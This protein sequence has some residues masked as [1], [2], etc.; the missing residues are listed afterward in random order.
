MLINKYKPKSSEEVYGQD[1]QLN[2]LKK[3]ILDKKPVLVYGSTGIGKT[4]SAYAL[5]Y[6][7]DYEILE[8]NASDL[9]NKEQIQTIV[10]NNLQQKSLFNKEKLVLID[11][12]DGINANDRGG[13]QE[14]LKLLH[15]KNFA[16]V[17]IANDPWNSKFKNLRKKCKL[18]EFKKI[19]NEII[20]N[21]INEINEK[22]KLNIPQDILKGISI[23][24]KGDLRSAILDLELAKISNK[25]ID[26][27]EKKENI[28]NVLK[29]LFKNKEFNANI[30]NNLDIDLDEI[31]LWLEENIPYE[32]SNGELEKAFNNLSKADIYRGRIKRWQY[33]RFLVY[34]NLLMAGIS[35]AKDKVNNKF[36]NYSRNSRILKIWIYNQKNVKKKEF[37]NNLAPNLHMSSKKLLHEMP[38]MKFL[39]Y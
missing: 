39:K 4:A 8:I 11:E 26:L 14:L 2:E 30:F 36:T 6:D 38:Y 19:D 35:L 33:Y 32:Y 10:K 24:A 29:F 21:F 17:I 37:V 15:G 25:N 22:E 34:Q 3:Y 20:F 18:I 12:I 13:L 16:I 9:R 23:N 7:L 31:M 27:R 28:F 1:P 5:A